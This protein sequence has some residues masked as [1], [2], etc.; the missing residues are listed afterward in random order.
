MSKRRAVQFERPCTVLHETERQDYL[1]YSPASSHPP[2]T[3]QHLPPRVPRESLQLEPLESLARCTCEYGKRQVYLILCVT[4]TFKIYY[5]KELHPGLSEKHIQSRPVEE[6]FFWGDD[7]SPAPSIIHN[8]SVVASSG[9]SFFPLWE[10]PER[11]H[12][13]E[14]TKEEFCGRNQ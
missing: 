1:H 9:G 13:F 10:S 6:D 14:E 8:Q 4:N 5:Q 12:T 2:T 11:D 3:V 7:S